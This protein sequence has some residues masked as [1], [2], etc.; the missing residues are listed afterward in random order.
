MST[1]NSNLYPFMTK[2]QIKA[3]IAEDTKFALHCLSVMDGRQTTGERE[4]KGTIVKNR[5]GWMS[6]H[7]KR[8]TELAALAAAGTIDLDQVELARALVSHYTKQL[9]AH[10]RQEEIDRN[11]DLAATASCFFTPQPTKG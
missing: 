10:F 7:A 9:A 1:N 2:A 5:A 11:P 8:G 3:R 6:S 4:V